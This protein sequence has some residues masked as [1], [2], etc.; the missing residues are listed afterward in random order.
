MKTKVNFISPFDVSIMK[1]KCPQNYIDMLIEASD[2][3]FKDEALCVRLDAS[4][5]LVGNVTNEVYVPQL[6]AIKKINFWIEDLAIKYARKDFL[7]KQKDY[8]DLQKKHFSKEPHVQITSEWLVRMNPGDF[9][10]AHFHTDCHLSGLLYLKIPNGLERDAGGN[11]HFLH[12]SPATFYTNQYQ[13]APKVGDTYLWP[14][15]LQH[16]VYPYKCKGERWVMP[17]NL[18]VAHGDETTVI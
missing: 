14:S 15:W 11:L 17:F 16:F 8:S 5:G 10:P 1:A 12:G 3:I 9:N 13:I 6:P 18:I 2:Q 4:D 7:K